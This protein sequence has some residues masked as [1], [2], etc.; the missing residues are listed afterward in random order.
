MPKLRTFSSH[1]REPEKMGDVIRLVL[2][3]TSVSLFVVWG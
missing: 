2:L 3:G 1:R